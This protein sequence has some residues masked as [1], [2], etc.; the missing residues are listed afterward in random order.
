MEKV[1]GRE[2]E[3]RK[4]E[5]GENTK[6]HLLSN[7]WDGYNYCLTGKRGA[8]YLAFRSARSGELS[9]VTSVRGF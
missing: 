6:A 2:Y 5:T 8:V 9:I 1:N 4:M 3:V 7:G